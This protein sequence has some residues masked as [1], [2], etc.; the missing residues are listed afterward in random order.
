MLRNHLIAAEQIKGT[1]KKRNK[2]KE[3]RNQV[4][5]IIWEVQKITGRAVLSKVADRFFSYIGKDI[6]MLKDYPVLWSSARKG[7]YM[8]SVIA[9]PNRIVVV[10]RLRNSGL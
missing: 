7:L 2:E 9:A 6:Q 1:K 8:L 5:L 3:L 4:Q 10:D